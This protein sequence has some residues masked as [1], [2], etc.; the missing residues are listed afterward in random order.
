MEKENN[1]QMKQ[2]ILTR[3]QLQYALSVWRLSND[4]AKSMILLGPGCQNVLLPCEQSLLQPSRN[5]TIGRAST[6]V[7]LDSLQIH[8]SFFFF[9]V[10]MK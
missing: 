1:E 10:H 4:M 7:L 9:K 2:K 5:G 3:K 6:S 8:L